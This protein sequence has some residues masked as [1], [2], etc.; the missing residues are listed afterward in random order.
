ME[1]NGW[2]I[3]VCPYYGT[4]L[5]NKRESSTDTCNN[6]EESQYIMLQERSQN[7]KV[8]SDISIYVNGGMTRT[9]ATSRGSGR[10]DWQRALENFLGW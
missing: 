4:L 2:V 1:G 10:I 8:Y 3:W 7:K 9:L 5:N 6:G